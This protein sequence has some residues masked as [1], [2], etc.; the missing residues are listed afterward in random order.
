M[1]SPPDF[2]VLHTND[3]HGKL[4]KAAATRI[5]MERSSTPNSILLDCGD[6][7]SS[8]NI[9]YRPGGEPIL[10]RMSDLGYDAMSMGNREFHFLKA[11]LHSKASLARFPILS[12]N[13]H[14]RP[15]DGNLPSLPSVNL[16]VN[17]IRIAIFGLTVPMITREM[18]VSKFSPYRFDD[19]IATASKIVPDL[20]R[21]CDF[22]IALT[23]IG[24]QKDMEL[25]ESVR[26]IDLVVGGHTHMVLSEPK[27]VGTTAIVQAGSW[28]RF[29]GRTEIARSSN[30]G[31]E[32]SERLI[33]L[34]I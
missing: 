17:E 33:D 20:R 19:P 11:G 25:A 30:G 4:T 21:E 26:G 22:L 12:A 34:S 23:H 9:Y 24:L 7:V 14:G 31:W 13:L 27:F 29:L 3:L 6:A 2:V 32:I 8:G 16:T 5:A 1:T 10:A 15:S 18:F 28:G